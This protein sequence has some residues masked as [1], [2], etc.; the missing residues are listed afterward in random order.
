MK[1][2]FKIY[3]AVMV[4]ALAIAA[5]EEPI[6]IIQEPYLKATVQNVGLTTFEV[7]VDVPESTPF[8]IAKYTKDEFNKNG[9]SAKTVA[10]SLKEKIEVGANWNSVLK[11]GAQV[12]EFSKL[13]VDTD[14]KV[15]VFGLNAAGE[16]TLDPV[17]LD[18]KTENVTF[19]MDIVNNGPFEYSMQVTPSRDDIGWY[20]FSFMGSPSVLRGLSD[21]LVKT[22][23]Q[24]YISNDKEYGDTFDEIAKVGVDT[25]E[26]ECYP[27]LSILFTLAA[28]DKDLKIVSKIDRYLFDPDLKDF[29]CF[30]EK[31]T[32]NLHTMIYAYDHQELGVLLQVTGYDSEDTGV[33]ANTM[34]FN[35]D[36]KNYFGIDFFTATDK[37]IADVM[38][39]NT[40][41]EFDYYRSLPEYQPYFEQCTTP[42]EMIELIWYTPANYYDNGRIWD[43]NDVADIIPYCNGYMPDEVVFALGI[44]KITKDYKIYP[45]EYC[46]S[47]C[48]FSEY[49]YEF[50][51]AEG[52]AAS[53]A[54]VKQHSTSHTINAATGKEY[55]AERIG[56]GS[57]KRK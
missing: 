46:I 27:D 1:S 30:D 43:R 38:S 22:Y 14:Y 40:Q 39:A 44:N 18:A 33:M 29:V 3:F 16:I 35:G 52:P 37:E 36:S 49:G 12:V 28:V 24:Y 9:I 17:V 57:L 31:S 48:S 47:R 19:K 42:Q 54:S 7:V 34:S 51:P 23:M 55:K 56:L 21:E 45:A 53:T 5:C 32:E 11:V 25:F 13:D 4:A 20:G 6:E 41:D 15:L 26:G 10:Q 50:T 8:Y 2:L